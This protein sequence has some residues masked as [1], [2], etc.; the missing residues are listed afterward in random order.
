MLG[1]KGAV[2]TTLDDVARTSR[3]SSPPSRRLQSSWS[4]WRRN[5]DG[6]L[7]QLT[8][9]VLETALNKEMTEHLG[10]EKHGPPGAGTGNNCDLS[11]DC[12]QKRLGVTQSTGVYR[13]LDAAHLVIAAQD[14]H[15]DDP[16]FGC[17]LIPMNC[18]NAAHPVRRARPPPVHRAWG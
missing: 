16:G 5:K 3:L 9:T 10:D 8:K 1:E 7:K 14:I 2:M 18:R 15:S 12:P 17:R 6:L 11:V 4:G 13:D